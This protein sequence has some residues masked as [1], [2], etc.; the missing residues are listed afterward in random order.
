M[1]TVRRYTQKAKAAERTSVTQKLC[2]T[3]SAPSH[4]LSS[5]AVGKITTK[6]REREMAKLGNPFP[7]PSKAPEEV[8]DTAEMKNPALMIRRARPPIWMVSGFWVKRPIRVS[9]M[10]KQRTVPSSM[11]PPLS[12]NT[13]P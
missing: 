9:G 2:Q 1:F 3:P 12:A 11:I 6:Y 13:Q 4:K 8:T 5:Q 10:A 7:N